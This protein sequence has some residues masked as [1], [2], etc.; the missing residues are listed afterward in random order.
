MLVVLGILIFF[1]GL[2]LSIAWHE[3]GHLMWAKLFGVKVTQYMVGF[4]RTIWSRKKGETEYGLKLIPL[5]GYIRMIGMFPP[6]KDEEYGRTASSSPWRTMIEDARQAVAEEVRPEDAHR[7]FYQRK[8]WK[9]VIVMF[10]GPFMN[11]ILAVVIFSGI[12]MGYGTPEPTTTVG[13]VSECVLPATAQ[14]TGQCP[15]GAPPTP[16]AAAGFQAGDRIVEFNGRPYASWDQLQLAIRQSS[17]TVPVVVERGGQRL[18]LHPSLVQNEMPNLKDT[19]QMVRVGFLGL[20]PTSALVK[21]DIPGV[22]NTMG[23]MIGMTVQKVIELPQRVP[24]LVSAIFG[25]ERQDDSPV[26]VVGASRLGGE[27]LSYD[28]FSVG[29]RIV[30]MFNLLAGVNLSLFVLN[31]L[32]ILPLDGGHIAGALW[33]SVRRKF[34]RLFR[35]PDPGPFD[36]ARLMPLAYGVSL[37]FIA[38]SLLVLVA[39]IVNPVT[40]F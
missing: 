6:K 20:A 3:L 33:E 29:A 32:P 27:V 18:T 24:D 2:L 34:A 9:R 39:D 35:R 23:E 17:G 7:Q 37:V 19:D 1:V 16:A 13:K 31:M 25:G 30:M 10:G 5:G 11:L 4:G 26:G 15:A 36:T 12:L 28:Q 22:V 21:Q 8:P 40:I 38:Y 14:N